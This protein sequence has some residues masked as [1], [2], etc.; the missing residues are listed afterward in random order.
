MNQARQLSKHVY[1]LIAVCLL[2]NT[3]S[4][5]AKHA[6][7]AKQP[8]TAETVSAAAT[9]HWVA[10]EDISVQVPYPEVDETQ[11]NYL[12]FQNYRYCQE[13]PQLLRAKAKEYS[14][15]S[16]SKPKIL[17]AQLFPVHFFW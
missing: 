13:Y 5:G 2:A 9:H 11:F 8:T 16:F 15:F 17:K 7:S 3:V 10:I 6:L 14:G 4:F 12:S 1:W